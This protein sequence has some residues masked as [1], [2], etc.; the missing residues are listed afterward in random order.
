LLAAEAFYHRH[1]GKTIVNASFLPFVRTYAPIIAGTAAMSYARF[2]VYNFVGA[3][4]WAIGLPVA[5]WALGEVVGEQLDQYLLV[6]LVGIV[7]ISI[8][9]TAFH[10][11]R[12]NREEIA[13]RIRSRG[14][15]GAVRV[16]GPPPAGTLTEEP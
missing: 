9:P 15:E 4:L 5:G 2:A 10:I 6:I 14:R 7:A 11:I 13:A 12:A 3:G 8:A 1:G 16:D